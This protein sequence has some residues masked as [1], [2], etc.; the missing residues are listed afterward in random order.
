MHQSPE[1][2]HP[3]PSTR[4]MVQVV[5][6]W[7]LSL[8]GGLAGLI[9]LFTFPFVVFDEGSGAI[10]EAVAFIVPEAIVFGVGIWLIRRSKK[11]DSG[12]RP[13]A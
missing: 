9:T 7:V 8:V 4:Q 6:G 10:W 12:H 3:K 13:T 1:N 2:S 5:I 11:P